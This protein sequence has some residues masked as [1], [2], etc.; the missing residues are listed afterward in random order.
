MCII[1]LKQTRAYTRNYGC[2]CTFSCLKP[3]LPVRAAVTNA[4]LHTLLG[5]CRQQVSLKEDYTGPY[6]EVAGAAA[7]DIIDI[8]G[9]LMLVNSH[10]SN[11]LNQW[12]LRDT[13]GDIVPIA[14]GYEPPETDDNGNTVLPGATVSVVG[15]LIIRTGGRTRYNVDHPF[16]RHVHKYA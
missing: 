4:C 2:L 1:A 10:N 7:A 12:F 8:F 5:N 11:A 13:N 14:S 3:Y 15:N 9:E 16:T 6:G